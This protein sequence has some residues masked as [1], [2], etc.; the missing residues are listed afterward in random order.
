MTEAYQLPGV[1]VTTILESVQSDVGTGDLIT[2][3]VG[4]CYQVE[5]KTEAEGV[6]T[7]D[8]TASD[9]TY[10]NKITG[11]T[12][13]TSTYAPKVY[14][15]LDGAEFDVTGTTG[16]SADATD[17]SLPADLRTTVQAQQ[18]DGA[19][20]GASP[21]SS[22]TSAR[23]SFITSGVRSGDLI[24]IGSDEYV[25]S[26]VVSNTRV[27]VV[28]IVTAAAAQTYTVQRDLDGG[29]VVIT[30]RAERD[31]TD[32]DGFLQAN[33]QS[34]LETLFGEDAVN[35]HWNPIGLGMSL[36]LQAGGVRV[37]GFV[38]SDANGYAAAV[39]EFQRQT[40]YNVVPLTMD[41]SLQD[42]IISHVKASSDN[43]GLERRAYVA[44]ATVGE[45][46]ISVGTAGTTTVAI[47]TSGDVTLATGTPAFTNARAGD[48]I[49]I[50]GTD[51][52]RLTAD[53][54]SDT[55]GTVAAIA[56]QVTATTD[57]IVE[58]RY[59]RDQE[60][61]AAASTARAIGSAR[62]TLVGGET[63]FINI[64][65]ESEELDAFYLAAIKAGQRSGSAIGQPLIR[66]AIPFVTNVSKG[67][68]YFTRG[69]LN[70]MAGAGWQLFVRDGVGSAVYCRDE[71]T[72]DQTIGPKNGQESE[73]V[74][75]DYAA[76]LF[77]DSLHPQLG[78]FNITPRT[79]SILRLSIDAIVANLLRERYQPFTVDYDC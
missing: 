60:A 20:D 75:R 22:F 33:G 79:L 32:I 71:L 2:V 44:R 31:D 46:D 74:A 49:V 27:E 53:P 48:Y 42:L 41:T 1:N 36:A 26:T 40:L 45:E 69:Q 43:D 12:I 21:N 50:G 15:Q 58:R 38:A 18:M 63:C 29:T 28:G 7:Y 57:F 4:P 52:Y 67:S 6:S 61:T 19:F 73:V 47:A 14:V 8:G 64:N 34:D 55:A 54:T 3:P 77:R 37:G 72:T 25:I 11:S 16:V 39:E 35:T 70:R 30:Y 9:F 68:D 59:T 10:P 66:A 24:V 78:R 5:I 56:T 17:V 76:Y 65:G 62:V 51:E 13:D 23:G